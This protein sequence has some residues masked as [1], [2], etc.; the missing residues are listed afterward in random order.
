[1]SSKIRKLIRFLANIKH[2]FILAT[3]LLLISL[4]VYNIVILSSEKY[5]IQYFYYPEEV[6][7]ELEKEAQKV[8]IELSN[9]KNKSFDSFQFKVL[10]DKSKPDRAYVTIKANNWNTSERIITISRDTSSSAMWVF[11]TEIAMFLESFITMIL[12]IVFL[13]VFLWILY[14]IF[15]IY[16]NRLINKK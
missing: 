8:V 10:S 1:M 5:K 15:W 4:L 9:F 11:E 13:F 6:Y 2:F 14:F 7:Q 16:E 3:V 12:D